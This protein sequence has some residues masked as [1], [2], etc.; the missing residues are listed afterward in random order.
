M[1]RRIQWFSYTLGLTVLVTVPKA[2]CNSE[3]HC[4]ATGVAVPAGCRVHPDR[5]IVTLLPASRKI[6]LRDQAK[7]VSGEH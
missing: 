3:Q 7:R 6:R 4:H 2:S 5:A 1:R